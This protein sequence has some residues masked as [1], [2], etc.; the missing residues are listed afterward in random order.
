MHEP[1]DR[2]EQLRQLWSPMLGK[3]GLPQGPLPPPLMSRGGGQNVLDAP[4]TSR[5][6]SG[7]WL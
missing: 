1:E 2:R 5:T 7:L 6:P 3:P 4:E